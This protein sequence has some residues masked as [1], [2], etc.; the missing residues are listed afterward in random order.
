MRSTKQGDVSARPVRARPRVE[1]VLGDITRVASGA[2]VNGICPSMTGGGAVDRAIRRAGGPVIDQQLE[3]IARER[4]PAGMP[5]AAC[6]ATGAGDMPCR[7]VLHTAGPMW[8]ATARASDALLETYLS[9]LQMAGD[10]G[11]ASVALPALCVGGCRFPVG[12]SAEVALRA[13][14]TTTAELSLVRFVLSSRYAYAEFVRAFVGG[15]KD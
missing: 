10:L 1:M 12:V 2:I 15:P 3:R 5:V 8:D 13:A 6:V 11:A 14:R 7:W 4:F 9:A